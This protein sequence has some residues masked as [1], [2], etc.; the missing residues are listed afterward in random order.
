ML[1]NQLVIQM[2]NI[3][4]KYDDVGI[5]QKWFLLF[6]KGLAPQWVPLTQPPCHLGPL[7]LAFFS[8]SRWLADGPWKP[9]SPVRSIEATMPISIFL[10]TTSNMNMLRQQLGFCNFYLTSPPLRPQHHLIT[11]YRQAQQGL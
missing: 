2:E 4:E 1:N 8:P 3:T 5:F 6:L 9:P 10:E 11:P 7:H